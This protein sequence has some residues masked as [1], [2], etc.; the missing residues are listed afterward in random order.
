MNYEQA[1]SYIHGIPKFSRVLGNER[2]RQLL[3]R[4][5]DP[6]K[7][8]RFI[9]IAGT[10]GKG[11]TAA[12]LSNILSCQGYR[13]GM[14]TSP[15]IERFNERIQIGNRY[16]E[17]NV[18]AEIA[19]KVRLCM[20]EHDVFVSEFAFVTAMAF[21]YFE[22]ENCDWVV[23]EVGMGGALDATN[24]ISQSEVSVLTPIGL[25]H[26]QYLGDT[27]EQIAQTKCGIIRE[28][29]TVVVS[30]GQP[31]EALEIIRRNGEQKHAEVIYAKEPSEREG[32]F[33]YGGKEY[34]LGLQGQFQKINAATALEVIN[35]L[36][37]KGTPV[38]E[39]AIREGLST[40][41]WM[42][43]FEFI[44]PN[45]VLDG[46]HNLDG[47]RVLAEALRAL[48]RSIILVLAMMQDKAYEACVKE[49][50]AVS[51]AVVATQVDMP[52]CAPARDIGA[53]AQKVC[54]DVQ[55]VPRSGE[56]VQAALAKAKNGELVCVCGSLY[57][58]GEVR[59]KFYAPEEE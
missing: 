46:G 17:D 39:A 18:L 47:I 2:L 3:G 55:V 54:G 1:I 41:H 5:G 33:F 58:A 57:L 36:K 40:V 6:Q 24:V 49:I 14:F 32:R 25:D 21:V 37:R 29:G 23:L 11:S 50:A 9:H 52:R 4:L 8:L 22:Q 53:V 26:M 35:V 38:S 42:A 48:D 7:R 16:I 28:N 56:A 10:N 30:A 43:R 12:M 51:T 59:R 13:T 20:E 27:I 34:T 45:L 31:E 44:R 19:S 15:F